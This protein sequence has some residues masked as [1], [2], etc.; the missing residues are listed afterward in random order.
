M[1]RIGI[2]HENKNLWERRAPLVPEHVKKLI[3]DHGV[4][5]VIQ[6]SSTRVFTEHEYEEV[7]ATTEQDF[8]GTQVVLAIKEVPIKLL[9]HGKTYVFFSHTIKGQDENMPMLKHV[10]DSEITLIDYEKIVN[11][12]GF[13]TVFFGNYAGLAG[14]GETMWGYGQK[15]KSLGIETQFTDLKHT[16][17]YGTVEKLKQAFAEV[18]KRI[19][20]EGLDERIV[21]VVCGFAGY[22]NVS[23]GAQSVYN[24]LPTIEI[25]PTELAE[26]I[27]K[28]NFSRKHVYKV[29]FKEEHMATPKDAGASFDLQHYYDTGLENY[30][31][32]FQQ[33]LPHLSILVNGIY[34]TEMFPRLVTKEDAKEL[35]KNDAKLKIIGDITCD[36]EGSIEATV[37]ITEP[38][39]SV[40]S[41]DPKTE[42]GTIGFKS[43]TLAIMAVDNLPCEL[44][45]ESSTAFSS[46]MITLI[47]ALAKADFNRSFED[48]DLPRELKDAVIVHRGEFT[49]PYRYMEEYLE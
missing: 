1:N 43:G 24:Q 8:S 42:K 47:P 37:M 25:D 14:M 44:P 49:E 10:I 15:L 5:I 18:G 45:R 40:F 35:A 12:K 30:D 6:A 33:Y 32:V 21:P 13:R 7:G 27:A 19:Q 39:N 9:E 38:D 3:D 23:S 16:Y 11:E 26:F 48:L 4:E 20:S 28:G 22:G 31:G 36:H 17:E 41:Y 2:R 29:V 46:T 34:W